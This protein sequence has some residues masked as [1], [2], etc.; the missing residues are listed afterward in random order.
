[1]DNNSR[2]QHGRGPLWA[3]S[4]TA[5]GVVYGDIGTSPLYALRECF[6]GPHAIQLDAPAVLGVLSLIVWT[7]VLTISIKYMMIVLRADNRGEGGILALTALAIPQKVRDKKPILLGIGLFGAALLYGDGIISPS[8]AVLSAVEGLKLATPMFDQ[9]VV[10]IA[11]VIL[12]VLFFMQ[13]YG[14]A[15]IG[16]VF[17]PILLVWF[18]TLAVL[19]AISV[20]ETPA[21]LWAVNPMYG[22][23]FLLTHG[24]EAFFVLGAVFLV[25]TGGESLYADMGHFGKSPIRVAWFSVVLPGLLI[26]YLGQGALLLRSP[27][28]AENPFYKLAP[29]WLLLPLIGLATMAAVIASQAV[30]AGVFS[31]T[32]QAIQ[33]GFCPRL[34]IVHTSKR[35][36]GQ[37]YLPQVNWMLFLATICVVINFGSSSNLAAAYGISVSTTMVITT[38]LLFLVQVSVWKWSWWV[39]VPVSIFFITIDTAYMSANMLKMG[40]G[41]WLPLS[42]G[43]FM[44]LLFATWRKGRII[45]AERLRTASIPLREFLSQVER[46]NMP[47]VPGTAVFMVGDPE[48]TPPALVHNVKHN[49]ILHK[50][51][52]ILTVLTKEIPH[53]RSKDRVFVEKI[54]P[55]FYRVIAHYGFIDSPNVVEI[56]DRCNAAG[57]ELN[58]PDITFFLGRE[59]LIASDHPGMAIWREHFFSFLSRNAQRA[60][61]FFNIPADQVIEVGMQ[62]EL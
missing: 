16:A 27:E 8:M 61:A 21:V 2:A 37:I 48:T 22:I 52:I 20:Y 17:G 59:T 12:A 58:L 49:K 50:T 42:I 30:I 39:A 6:H 34:Q 54:S 57:M 45:L 19:G 32:R 9:Y 28:A 7:L 11:C 33:L 23:D 38:L 4:L 46:K 25:A 41:G 55:E 62:V 35:E 44:Y 36:I 47:R 18:S 3:M 40:Q 56:V 60:T 26:N 24:H 1:M 14:T 29:E 43:L 51:I 15:K 13:K 53:V 5:L 31:L 10:P